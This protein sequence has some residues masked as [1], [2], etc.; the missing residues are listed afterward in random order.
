MVD[1]KI[2]EGAT[3]DAIHC[4]ECRQS[5]SEALLRSLLSTS[6]MERLHRQSLESAVSSCD[7]LRP[8]PTPDCPNR[9]V[10]EDGVQPRLR[11]ELCRKEHC[12]LCSASPYHTGKTCEEHLR[13]VKDAGAESALKR[14]MAE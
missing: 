2:A 5:L 12:L 3:I 4:P 7:T 14:W 10:L 11:C 1:A 13:E 6:Q 9:V 8:C